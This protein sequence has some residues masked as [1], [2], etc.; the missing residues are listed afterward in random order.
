MKLA[1]SK[2]LVILSEPLLE[3]L[4]EAL[5]LFEGVF[6]NNLSNVALLFVVKSDVILFDISLG[7]STID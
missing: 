1:P 2:I 4:L 7:A 6:H 3:L 5:P